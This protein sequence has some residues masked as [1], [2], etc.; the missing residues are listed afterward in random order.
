LNEQRETVLSEPA[1]V[2][3]EPWW[4]AAVL[5]NGIQPIYT[6]DEREIELAR[7]QL[8]ILGSP[9]PIGHRAFEIIAASA[10]ELVTND[11]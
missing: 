5:P 6:S 4:A 8:R 2:L 11:E 7:R 10:G 1:P 9:V 3:T